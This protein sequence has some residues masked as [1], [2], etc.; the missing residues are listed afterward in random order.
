MFTVRL[1]GTENSVVR[2][3][4]SV[5]RGRKIWRDC[6]GARHFNTDPQS[7]GPRLKLFFKFT[8]FFGCFVMC[9]LFAPSGEC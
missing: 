5:P 7:L 8:S 6:E 9:A 3:L 4:L 2:S 1:S